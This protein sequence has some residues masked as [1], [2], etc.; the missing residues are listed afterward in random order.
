MT[1][2]HSQ[3][4]YLDRLW[5]CTWKAPVWSNSATLTE[6]DVIF[7]YFSLFLSWSW[8]N[9]FI[10]GS[11]YMRPSKRML[12]L[13]WECYFTYNIKGIS[14]HFWLVFSMLIELWAFETS[15]LCQSILLY[16]VHFNKL[17]IFNSLDFTKCDLSQ[18]TVVHQSDASI[19]ALESYDSS[20]QMK[21]VEAKV[22]KQ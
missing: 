22:H 21:G 6:L 19:N 12:Q 13:L 5:F 10:F 16:S 9:W 8:G 1:F 2:L 15:I 4:I 14:L 20:I 7:Q 3:R 17:C 18:W 11:I